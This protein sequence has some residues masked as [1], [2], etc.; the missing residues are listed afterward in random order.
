MQDLRVHGSR[1][2]QN[3]GLAAV[4]ASVVYPPPPPPPPHV[5]SGHAASL[6]PYYSATPRPSPRN[7]VYPGEQL[8]LWVKEAR[9]QRAHDAL[10]SARG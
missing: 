1:A 7:V 2:A 9:L 3:G 8:S 6:T 10:D 5:L 4:L